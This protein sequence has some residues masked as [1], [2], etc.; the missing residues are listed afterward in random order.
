MPR[1][2][3][4]CLRIGA[5]VVSGVLWAAAFPPLELAPI[6]WVALVPLFGASFGASRAEAFTTAFAAWLAFWALYLGWS[7]DLEGFHA[8]H[9]LLPAG[10]LGLGFAGF[11]VVLS[12]LSRTAPRWIPLTFAAAWIC[13]EKLRLGLDF[14]AAP[15]GL[16]GDSQY[17]FLPLIQLAAWTGNL[18]ISFLVAWVNAAAARWLASRAA[19][20]GVPPA[21]CARLGAA[22]AAVAFT[23]TGGSLVLAFDPEREML[24][25]ALVQAG[26]YTHGHDPLAERGAVWERY[27][28]LTREV[29][30]ERPALVAWPSSSMPSLIPADV[31]AVR[32]L[33]ALARETGAFLL[34][35]S[36]GQEKAHPAERTS[37]VANSAFLISPGSEV[38]QRYDKIRLLPFNEYLPL[39]GFVRWPAWLSGDLVDARAGERRS[40]F[41]VGSARFAVLICWE[42]LFGSDFRASAARG[43][44]FMVGMTNEAFTESRAGH[45]QMHAINVMRAVENGVSLVRPATTGLSSV[46]DPRGR[47]LTR[48]RDATGRE[49]GA[50]AAG[51][52][53][54]PLAPERSFY[55]RAGDWLVIVA[56]AGLLVA[57]LPARRTRR[58]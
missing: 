20:S 43:V 52:V 40:V 27:Q 30:R 21:A 49:L 51:V 1:L 48:L 23:V 58:A 34:V 53:E 36:T 11:G 18:G 28:R 47:I 13:A 37:S 4:S 10:V 26:V 5:G 16:L 7:F 33:G 46:I 45:L 35:G 32:A 12:G 6:A 14:A 39:R 57:L 2:R 31:S 29:A 8:I 17:R 55:N 38:E 41:Q 50:I 24:R 9:F 42:N 15:W 44:D 22:L 56:G 19:G 25:V 3:A 54:V